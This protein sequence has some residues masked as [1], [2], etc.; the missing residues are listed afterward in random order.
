LK[1]Q[2]KKEQLPP[3]SHL[4]T[5]QAITL[6]SDGETFG[7]GTDM[8][9]FLADEGRKNHIVLPTLREDMAD[10]IL[11]HEGVVEELGVG[12]IMIRHGDSD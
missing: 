7:E 8:G 5:P 12:G 11:N 1:L 4:G 6:P 10:E 9:R 3:G 2:E